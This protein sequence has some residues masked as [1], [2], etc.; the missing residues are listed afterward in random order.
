[1]VGFVSDLAMPWY[2]CRL[3]AVY[4]TD[5]VFDFAGL[6]GECII[7]GCADSCPLGAGLSVDVATLSASDE[8]VGAGGFEM[9][10]APSMVGSTVETT[11]K[12]MIDGVKVDR[13]E[14]RAEGRHEQS[15]YEENRWFLTQPHMACILGQ[16]ASR[17]GRSRLFTP[18]YHFSANTAKA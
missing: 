10:E 16:T 1:V 5:F 13:L 8:L 9:S 17:A 3:P 18:F 7:C 11:R 4:I 15:P 6:Y 14:P 12:V 2:V